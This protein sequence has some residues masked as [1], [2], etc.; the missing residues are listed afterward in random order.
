METNICK[1]K[2]RRGLES[3][4]TNANFIPEEGEPIFTTDSH[5][6]CIGD[7]AT[8]GGVVFPKTFIKTD[9]IA[10]NDNYIKQGD[11][12]YDPLSG[13][14][15][16][17]TDNEHVVIGGP[18][19][20]EFGNGFKL[21]GKK[22][23]LKSGDGI[24]ITDN[25]ISMSDD[26]LSAFDSIADIE[27]EVNILSSNSFQNICAPLY[28]APTLYANLTS[29]NN[30]P[31][32][33][34]LNEIIPDLVDKGNIADGKV[35]ELTVN[36]Q[37]LEKYKASNIAI[38]NN[39]IINFDNTINLVQTR[40]TY[41]TNYTYEPTTSTYTLS[42]TEI[43]LPRLSVNVPVADGEITEE[44]LSPDLQKKINDSTIDKIYPV[45]SIYISVNDVNPSELFGGSWEQIKDRFLLAAGNTYNAG[46]VGGEATHKL[47][48]DEIPTH[49]HQTKVRIDGQQSG[50]GDRNRGLMVSD[51]GLG[52]WDGEWCNSNTISDDMNDI[53]NKT[54]HVKNNNIGGDQPH[55]NMP[56]YLTV[57]MWKRTS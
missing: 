27:S 21:D 28:Q 31:I 46:S 45:G 12:V 56:P 36:K 55:N 51:V 15:L 10:L 26:K 2:F 4:R 6:F 34:Q 9:D 29:A 16:F 42:T 37:L 17:T 7:G 48:V 3:E 30:T 50:S 24:S 41:I 22:L 11:F 19:T 40:D 43:A 54:A 23:S 14:Q 57:Y 13:L 20:Y 18:D 47:T 49:T 8:P 32:P 44:K 25:G 53:D 33:I 38:R 35:Y 5:R 52:S 1:I 39:G